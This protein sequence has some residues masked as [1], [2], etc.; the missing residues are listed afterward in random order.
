[1][2]DEIPAAEPLWASFQDVVEQLT[3]PLAASTVERVAEEVGRLD[4]SLAGLKK[5]LDG[6]AVEQDDNALAVKKQQESLRREN[7]ELRRQ[8]EALK[9]HLAEQLQQIHEAQ[10]AAARE[11]TA[12]VLRE[13][14]R[15]AEEAR[16]WAADLEALRASR[17]ASERLARATVVL[18]SLALFLGAVG[19]VLLSSS[20]Y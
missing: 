13:L 20:R 10:S 6:L 2:S 11:D 14:S 12:A 7:Q 8:L 19:V 4:K 18:L 17:S 5:D 9:N 16:T 15:A 1:M 3:G